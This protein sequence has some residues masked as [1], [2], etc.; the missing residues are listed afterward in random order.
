M[1]EDD[2]PEHP[3][4]DG[5]VVRILT[6]K[7]AKPQR[8][9]L[10]VVKTARARTLIKQALKNPGISIK[11]IHRHQNG[12][13]NLTDLMGADLIWST[14]CFAIP[15]VTI[16]GRLSEDGHWIIH[17]AD[18]I[19]TQ[20]GQWER[21]QWAIRTGEKDLH[22][23]FTI[24]HRA[25]ALL[26]VLELIAQLGINGHSIQGKGRSSDL[27]IVTVQLGGKPIHV[28][29]SFLSQLQRVPSVREILHYAW[30]A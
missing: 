17:R 2:L 12:S 8:A 22:I 25:G 21:G 23:T 10:E 5:D 9:W 16:V 28:L 24:D 7:Q 1:A 4:Q 20:G 3:L 29:A 30:K 18:C 14:C 27:S 26:S 6:S 11:G 19:K 13:F 15:G